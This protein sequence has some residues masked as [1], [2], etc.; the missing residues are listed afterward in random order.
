MFKMKNLRKNMAIKK[1]NMTTTYI[2][3]GTTISSVVN[4]LNDYISNEIALPGNWSPTIFYNDL[5]KYPSI[6]KLALSNGIVQANLE[7]MSYLEFFEKTRGYS[8]EHKSL[9]VWDIFNNGM[10]MLYF[11]NVF[12]KLSENEQYD[13][14]DKII[15]MYMKALSQSHTSKWNDIV[16]GI[17]ACCY[18]FFSKEPYLYIPLL[19]RKNI[20]NDLTLLT[21]MELLT[22]LELTLSPRKYRDK[23]S[24]DDT[25]TQL[26]EAVKQKYLMYR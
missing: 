5:K 6:S 18:Q 19:S 17:G 12:L 13:N 23:I 26:I 16:K 8:R 22:K 10:I 9:E 11:E 15:L 24:V 2:P 4:S 1:I 14:D 21:D 3:S 20:D 7:K 25:R